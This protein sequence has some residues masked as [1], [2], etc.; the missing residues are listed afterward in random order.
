MYMFIKCNCDSK[1]KPNKLFRLNTTTSFK[2]NP[3]ELVNW[4]ISVYMRGTYL[5]DVILVDR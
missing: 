1:Y 3:P 4:L 5:K 2:T